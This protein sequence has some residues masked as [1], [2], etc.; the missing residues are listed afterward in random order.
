MRTGN[1]TVPLQRDSAPQTEP[2]FTVAVEIVRDVFTPTA[3]AEVLQP[4]PIGGQAPDVQLK[5]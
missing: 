2:S 4:S 5:E 3:T 1:T